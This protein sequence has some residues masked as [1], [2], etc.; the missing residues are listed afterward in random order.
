MKRFILFACV[1]IAVPVSN[2]AA[3]GGFPFLHTRPKPVLLDD[4]A[5]IA[6]VQARAPYH[7]QNQN[8]YTPASAHA[9]HQTAAAPQA[10][11]PRLS[12]VIT[13]AWHYGESTHA[14]P[15]QASK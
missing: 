13:R 4:Q 11:R 2:A 5:P 3:A 14:R 6:P 10:S 12:D 1:A 7:P 15:V 8:S 9:S